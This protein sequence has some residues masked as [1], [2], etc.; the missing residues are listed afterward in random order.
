MRSSSST[1]LYLCI[2]MKQHKFFRLVLITQLE[3]IAQ[4]FK[5]QI[6]QV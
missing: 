3:E 2:L 6:L 1:F 5:H 4:F